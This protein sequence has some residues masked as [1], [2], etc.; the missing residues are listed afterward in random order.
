MH[1]TYAASA[2]TD[3]RGHGDEHALLA[4]AFAGLPDAI[5]AADLDSRVRLVN[6]AAEALLGVR[7]SEV[8]RPATSID[9][10]SLPPAVRAAPR[11]SVR[12]IAAGELDRVTL[13]TRMLRGDGS[14]FHAEVVGLRPC[15]SAGGEAIGH[16]SAWCA[17]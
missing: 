13:P 10:L 14:D 7:E 8:L 6:P 1:E 17:T 16:R 15:A 4:A 9:T 3:R 2:V 11:E 5:V 12:T